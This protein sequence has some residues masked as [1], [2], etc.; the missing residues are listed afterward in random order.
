MSL[1]RPRDTAV[2]PQICPPASVRIYCG[3]ETR[4]SESVR[5]HCD[6]AT[7]RVN[8]PALRA[9]RLDTDGKLSSFMR[10]NYLSNYAG[11][12]DKNARASIT[13]PSLLTLQNE[14]FIV[15]GTIYT[16]M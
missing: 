10:D 2:T 7:Q 14:R 6:D 11:T 13:Y 9:M 16:E 5:I 15:R 1:N 4:P 12:R 3:N 8:G